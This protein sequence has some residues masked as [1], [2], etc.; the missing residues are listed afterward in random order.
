MSEAAVIDQSPQDPYAIPLETIDVSRA[1]IYEE[2]RHWAFFERLRPVAA[3]WVG[4]E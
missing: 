1:D 3:A 2:D 4:G